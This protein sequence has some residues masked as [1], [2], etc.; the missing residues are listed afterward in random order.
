MFTYTHSYIYPYTYTHSHIYIYIHTYICIFTHNSIQGEGEGKG[1]GGPLALVLY[2]MH[3]TLCYSIEQH[4][5]SY[6]VSKPPIPI[7]M[8]L[9]F[10]PKC[11]IL[12]V[13]KFKSRVKCEQSRHDRNYQIMQAAPGGLR[14]R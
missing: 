14:K 7:Q 11:F 1:G 4:M 12:K 2:S 13:C 3:A 10:W 8:M 9:Y 6:G 5:V